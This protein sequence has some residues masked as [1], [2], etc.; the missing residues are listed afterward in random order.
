M[1]LSCKD[2]SSG[3]S[4]VV[5]SAVYVCVLPWIHRNKMN[6]FLEQEVVLCKIHELTHLIMTLYALVVIQLE[7]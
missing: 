5:V 6:T 7:V 3:F 1:W 2:S 4:C